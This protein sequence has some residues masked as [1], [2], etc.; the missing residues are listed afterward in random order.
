[1][2]HVRHSDRRR[3]PGPPLPLPRG[4]ATPVAAFTLL[5]VTLAMALLFSITF[6]LLQITSTNLRVAKLL[7][8]TTIDA[9]SL[10]AELSL[11]NRLEE[12]TESGDFGD[13]Y[14]NHTWQREITLV[15]TNGLYECRFE[16]LGARDSTPESE[17]VVLLYRPDSARGTGGARLRGR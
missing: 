17:L 16:V 4:R 12:G 1:M 11:T 6:I 2:E 15:G 10:A 8:R 13:L 5:E 3:G 7:Q 14:P 9:S